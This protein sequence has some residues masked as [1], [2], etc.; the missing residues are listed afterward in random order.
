MVAIQ[1]TEAEVRALVDGVSIAA[2]NGPASV[3]ISGDEAAV[4]AVAEGFGK[5]QR[6]RVSHAF[7]SHLMDP[8]LDRVRARSSPVWSFGRR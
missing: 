2:V 7:H 3:V 8:M 4:L 1:A 5:T 6:L